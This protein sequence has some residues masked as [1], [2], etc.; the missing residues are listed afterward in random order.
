M[1]TST[2]LVMAAI[3]IMPLMH[4]AAARA[5]EGPNTGASASTS[6]P[7]WVKSVA[8]FPNGTQ[9]VSASFDG[10][11]KVWDAGTGKL[12]RTLEIKGKTVHEEEVTVREGTE[13][14]GEASRTLIKTRSSG[15][16]VITSV[17]VSPDG[18]RI[19]I[20]TGSGIRL[21]DTAKDEFH[22]IGAGVGVYSV[23]FSPDGTRVL[24]GGPD[25]TLRLWDASERKSILEVSEGHF[26]PINSVAFSPDG[27]LALYASS[28][29][30]LLRDLGT[31]K[32][33]S[34]FDPYRPDSHRHEVMAVA[35]SRDGTKI[36][37]GSQDHRLHLRDA[38][39]GQLIRSLYRE[40]GPVHAVAF[41]PDGKFILSGHS[42]FTAE[43]V[44]RLWD[45]ATGEL[46]RIF[47]GHEGA[48]TSLAFSPDGTRA[49]SGSYDKT[50]RLWDVATGKLLRT[51]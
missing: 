46:L 23:A 21:W 11:V 42:G 4:S 15:D 33:P 31:G 51:F 32:L 16:T 2:A 34:G 22:T 17:A 6:H 26:G 25:K 1:K 9:I 43:K 36:L 50:V 35:F 45:A 10:T 47:E 27:K 12:L 13:S 14:G 20:G 8:F 24:S 5:A 39:T 30:V 37:S 3:L 38:A 40:E 48:V 28:L 44:L 29:M 49:V 18:T 7:D 19:L 41:S